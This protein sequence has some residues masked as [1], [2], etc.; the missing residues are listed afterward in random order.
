MDTKIIVTGIALMLTINTILIAMSV[1]WL[2]R[3]VVKNDEA[4]TEFYTRTDKLKLDLN[5]I[6]TQHNINHPT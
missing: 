5:T 3:F 2:K 1:W 6:Q 4:H